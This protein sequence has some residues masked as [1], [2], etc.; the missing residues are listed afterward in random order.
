MAAKPK[1]TPARGGARASPQRREVPDTPDRV[2]IDELAEK[3]AIDQHDLNSALIVQP[4]AMQDVGDAL[5]FAISVRDA[6]K[7]ELKLE[8]AYADER[9]RSSVPAGEKVTETYVAK[10][11]LL[12][13]KYQDAQKRL[14][15]AELRV[16]RLAALKD[17]FN[18]RSYAIKDLVTLHHTAYYSDDS[19]SPRTGL[20]NNRETD[21]I[22]RKH[23]ENRNNRNNNRSR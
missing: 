15:D 21:A 23:A 14:R 11:V 16:G 13:S 8:E 10:Q 4:G 7:D 18:Q 12:D 2:N 20:G 19:A 1:S 17:S 6:C 9:V 3:L 22:K 5:A